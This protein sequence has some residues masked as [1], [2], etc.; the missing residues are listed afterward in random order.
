MIDTRPLFETTEVAP[1]TSVPSVMGADGE[2]P[3]DVRV[4]VAWV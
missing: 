3:S 4:V 1:A 2:D